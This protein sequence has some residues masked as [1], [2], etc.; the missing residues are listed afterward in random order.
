[1]AVHVRHRSLERRTTL[2]T[3]NATQ[4]NEVPRLKFERVQVEKVAFSGWPSCFSAAAPRTHRSNNQKNNWHSNW[5]HIRDSHSTSDPPSA[6]MQWDRH[7]VWPVCAPMARIYCVFCI[8]SSQILWLR[9]VVLSRAFIWLKVPVFVLNPHSPFALSTC[10]S[11]AYLGDCQPCTR[12]FG[13]FRGMESIFIPIFHY[14]SPFSVSTS[15]FKIPF[16]LP[17]HTWAVASLTYPVISVFKTNGLVYDALDNFAVLSRCTEQPNRPP[18]TPQPLI[19]IVAGF[20]HV[21][22]DSAEINLNRLNDLAKNIYVDT[23]LTIILMFI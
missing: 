5:G 7:C 10:A 15:C 4:I 2:S 13:C 12:A 20:C 6:D 3:F 21:N 16:R 8:C 9:S 11:G 18:R 17:V 1:M 19:L 14:S 23:Q 22:N